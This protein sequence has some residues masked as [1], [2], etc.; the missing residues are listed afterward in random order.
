MA[1]KNKVVLGIDLGGTQTKIGFVQKDGTVLGWDV[2][3]SLGQEP[4][5]NFVQQLRTKYTALEASIDQEMN[6]VGVGIGAPN[7]NFYTG[8]MERAHNFKWGETVPLVTAVEKALS[9]KVVIT[10]DA[11]LV[12]IGEQEY[13]IGKGMKNFIVLTLGTGVGSG[14][15]VNG[16]LLLGDSGMAG[17]MG[18]VNVNPNGRLCNCGLRGCLE[19]YASVTGIKRTVFKLI[20]DMRTPSIL[21]EYSYNELTG[22]MIAEAA[23]E[24]DPIAMRAFEYTGEIL[25]TKLADAGA[26][27]SPEAIIL[28]GGLTKAGDLL[29]IPTKKSME[30]RIFQAFR[31]KIKL[32]IS[33]MGQKYDGVLGAAALAWRQFG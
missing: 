7:A 28:A 13:G 10:N 17:E 16:E 30:A 20:A 21:R 29:L 15:I 2:F 6:V 8:N 33:D 12:A 26:Y 9:T 31:G 25:G 27:F 1:A 3:S 24:G 19:T 14:F 18:H 11:N 5:A 23:L 22:K 32:L 4:F